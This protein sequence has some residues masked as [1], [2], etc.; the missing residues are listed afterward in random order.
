MNDGPSVPLGTT[1]QRIRAAEGAEG[2]KGSIE[3]TLQV[4]LSGCDELRVILSVI[5]A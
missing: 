3:R 2:L 1:A 4:F 5:F